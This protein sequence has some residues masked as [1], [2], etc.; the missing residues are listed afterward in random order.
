MAAPAIIVESV[1]PYCCGTAA[2]V[3][4][5]WEAPEWRDG[6][7]LARD[8]QGRPLQTGSKPVGFVLALPEA[9]LTRPVPVAMY[10][11]GSPGSPERE[12]PSESTRYLAGAGFA[13]IGF[14]DAINR[15]VGEDDT[16]QTAAVFFP[17]LERRRIPDFWV[18]TH[19]EQLAFLRVIEQ[20]DTLD[21]LPIDAPDGVPEVD[22]QQPLMYVGISAGANSGQAFLPYAP[23]VRA[24]ALVAGGA[25]L[26]ETLIYQQSRPGTIQF[27]DLLASIVP[28]ATP[29]DIWTGFSLFAA[30]LEVQDDQS[31][32][33]FLYRNPIDVGGDTRKASI[34]VLEG[35]NDTAVPN[36]ATNSL[37]WLMGPIPHLAPVQRPVPFLDVVESPLTANIDEHTTAALYQYV[38]A[39][40][41]GIDATPGCAH[42]SDGHFCPQIA[43]ESY[44]QRTV[45]FQS[46]LNGSAPT[47]IDPLGE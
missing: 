11:H 23:E 6:D 22:P 2:V 41:P 18:E 10:Q 37:A 20:L 31:H 4:G 30:G 26:A 9:A 43:A 39:G 32:A 7:F 27:V 42:E 38:P 14:Q 34:L 25:R 35:V 15:E 33:R 12:V 16:A 29:V 47:I 3:R 21:L 45:F 40:V 44:R 17:L 46:A 36:N 1:E 24:A 8:E 19:G 13:V 5:T 28:N